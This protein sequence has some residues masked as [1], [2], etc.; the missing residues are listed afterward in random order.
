MDYATFRKFLESACVY[1]TIY[2]DS[3]GREIIVMKTIDLY[4]FINDAI[5][6]EKNNVGSA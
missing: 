1:E 6:K 5:F 4:A 3:D 2:T